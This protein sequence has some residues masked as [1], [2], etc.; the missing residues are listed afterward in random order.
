MTTQ[1]RTASAELGT[2]AKAYL[3]LLAYPPAAVPFIAAMIARLPIAMAPL[4]L[5]LLVEH[6]RN[7]YGKAGFV[8][9][10]FAIGCAVGTPLWG[11]AMDRLG[12]VAVVLP[13]SLASAGFLIATALATVFGAPMPVL[14][15]LAGGA[16]LTFPPV[17][18]AMRTAWRVIFPN[19]A[20]RRVAF[21]LDATAV[22]L[23]FVL[24]PLLLSLLLAVSAP[25]VPLLV[26]AGCMVVGGLVY[27]RTDAARRSRP[28]ETK[29]AADD[30]AITVPRVHRSAITVPGVFNVLLVVLALSLGFG[31]LDTSLAGTAGEV[32]GSN[33]QLGILFTAIAGGSVVGGLVFGSRDWPFDQRRVLPVL[34]CAFALLLAAVAGLV[35]TGEPPLWLLLPLLFATGLTIAPSIIALQ[36]MIDRLTPSSRMNEAQS[37]FSAI[38][39]VGA[40]V[41][42]AVAGLLIDAHGLTWSFRGAAIAIAVCCLLSIVSQPLWTRRLVVLEAREPVVVP[43]AE[44]PT[45]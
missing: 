13:T 37:M 28:M 16:G 6:E 11:R 30:A 29:S 26:T 14:I 24:G 20:A 7:A 44:E 43:P 17:S 31:Q 45:G 12:Q 2:G 23:L 32:L 34:T 5:L 9:G 42:T 25:V 27:C 38:N 18:P 39:Q 40:A 4:G 10:A 22:E 15:A 41:G 1:P 8:T 3:K 21:A 33:D 36:G 19:P 35:G